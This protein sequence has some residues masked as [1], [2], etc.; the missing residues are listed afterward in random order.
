MIKARGRKLKRIA[1]MIILVLI[2]LPISTTVF[3]ANLT[4][5]WT[6]AIFLDSDNNLDLWAQKDLNEMMAVGS[7]PSMNII[8]YWDRYDGPAHCYKVVKDN[9]IELKDSK[10]NGI[11]PNM[12]D[13]M[14]LREFVKYAYGKFP[15]RK[16]AILCFDHG[17]DF[18]GC[19]YDEHIPFE[20]FDLLTHQEV[21]TALSN[22][23]IDVL[24]Y[25]ACV[26]STIEVAYEYYASGLDINYYV[27]NE[28]YDPMD[29]FPY[30]QILSRLKAQPN[31]EPFELSRI[32]VDEYIDYY[33]Y[34]GKAYSQ[35]VTLSVT[36]INEIGKVTSDTKNM[37]QAIEQD[38]QGYTGIV[39][40]ARGQA[41][42]PWSENGWERLIDLQTFVKTIHNESLKPENTKNIEPTVKNAVLSS[43]AALLTSLSNAIVYHRNTPA[44]EK[45]GCKGIC[46]YFPTS[47]GSYQNNKNLYGS[48]YETMKFAGEGWL[49]FLNAYWST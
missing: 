10:L 45:A 25:S 39:S 3:A 30:D 12:G 47:Q 8:V 9:L 22:F 14:T 29:G 28:G 5:D 19:M 7:T 34:T 20:G 36:K 21:V 11:E 43:S 37:V 2:L 32:F 44:M 18:R 6:L 16:H 33:T 27:A 13:P 42:L 17:D 35:A 40:D 46:V 41:N 24:I 23:K 15:A 4:S 1:V 48:L 38:M 26:L 49:G 31:I